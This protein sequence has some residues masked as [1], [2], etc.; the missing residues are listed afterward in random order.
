M[1]DGEPFIARLEAATEAGDADF[2][3]VNMPKLERL[4]ALYQ[5]RLHELAQLQ[6]RARV[7]CEQH[8]PPASARRRNRK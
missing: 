6:Y 3:E 8:G 4:T 1:L 7:I 2:I 5:E